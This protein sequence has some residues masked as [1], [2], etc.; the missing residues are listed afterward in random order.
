MLKKIDFRF[1]VGGMTAMTIAVLTVT[2]DVQQVIYFADPINE[3]FFAAMFFT[4][5]IIALS[6]SKK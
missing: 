5:G 4:S 2:G 3:M 6:A 1:L